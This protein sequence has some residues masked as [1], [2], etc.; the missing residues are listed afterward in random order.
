M[1]H[2]YRRA[3]H[4]HSEQAK[5]MLRVPRVWSCNEWDQLEEV[6]VG[7]PLKCALSYGG[8]KHPAGRISRPFTG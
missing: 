5:G 2:E 6:I 7:N 4:S 1:L 8:S 3:G